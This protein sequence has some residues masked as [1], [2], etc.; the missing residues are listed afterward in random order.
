MNRKGVSNASDPVGRRE[1]LTPEDLGEINGGAE[2]ITI[3]G[4]RYSESAERM[5]DR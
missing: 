2:R 5:V 4:H 1:A 3:Q